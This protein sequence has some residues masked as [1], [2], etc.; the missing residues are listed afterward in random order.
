MVRN[1]RRGE[2]RARLSSACTKGSWERTMAANCLVKIRRSELAMRWCPLA[3][4]EDPEQ[5]RIG[6]ATV[7]HHLNAVRGHGGHA[8]FV[9]QPA[10]LVHVMVAGDDELADGGIDL[11]HLEHGLAARITGVAAVGA[12]GGL[13]QRHALVNGKAQT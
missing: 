10:Y 3:F 5:L 4:A 6:G 13:A 7:R 1:E 2:S 9:C 11:Q 8:G 12:A